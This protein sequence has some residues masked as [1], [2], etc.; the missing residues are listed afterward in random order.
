MVLA[1]VLHLSVILQCARD[2]DFLKPFFKQSEAR[3]F[4]VCDV[5]TATLA[6]ELARK[7]RGGYTFV[8]VPSSEHRRGW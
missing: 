8:K 6:D 2:R 3:V 1:T 4:G 5:A 7:G